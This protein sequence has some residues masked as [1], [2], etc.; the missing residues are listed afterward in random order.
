MSSLSV[1][2]VLYNAS[3]KFRSSLVIICLCLSP[4][5]YGQIKIHNNSVVTGS[6]VISTNATITNVSPN[7]D[8]S[9]AELKLLNSGDQQVNTSQP[10]VIKDLHIDQG[11]VK[12]FAGSWEIVGSLSLINGIIKPDNAGKFLYSGTEAIEGNESSYV[13]GFL[14]RKGTGQ[15]TFPIGLNGVYAPATLEAAPNGE[16]GIRVFKPG[17]ALTLPP[18]VISSFSEHQWEI[19]GAV[20]SPVSLS[21][22]NI[23]DFLEGGVPIV[24]Q[25]SAAGGTATSLSGAANSSFVTSIDNVTQSFVAIGKEVEFSLVIHDLITPYRP[26]FNDKLVIENI[27]KISDNK[28]TLLDRWGMI[29]V[30]WRNFTNASDY[31][32]TKLPPGNYICVVEYTY[33]GE[34][35]TVSVKGM[36][37]ILKSK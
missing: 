10:V 3:M 29:A 24:L 35:R 11:G 19:N 37:T 1:Q 16:Y 6:G 34:T 8:L 9:D 20:N 28:V 15:L 25:A 27:E 17:V 31:D 18:N 30:Q 4:L 26:D 22:N 13:D 14:F 23:G 21:L 32:F 5:T 33:P 12:T 7:V 36:V 2:R